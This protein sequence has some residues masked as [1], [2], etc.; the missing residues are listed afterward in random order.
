MLSWL[1]RR[2]LDAFEK[3]YAYDASYARE[4]LALS[5]KALTKFFRAASLGSYRHGLT[6]E[7]WH[8]ARLVSIVAEDCG[9]CT[10]LAVTMAERA[11]VA[12]ELIADLIAGRFEALP[13]PVRVTA[14]FT[15]ATLRRTPEADELRERVEQFFGRQGLLSI[16]FSITAS[17]MYPTLKY[18]MGYGR[19]CQ[20]VSVGGKT[21][22]P[23]SELKLHGAMLQGQARVE[24]V[25]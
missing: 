25:A 9:P 17:R 4:M 22:A 8:A 7:A 13:E 11:G 5:P 19:S 23:A 16:A 3:S 15:L 2:R 24:A 14:R 10:Q 12:P 1:I 6:R 20:H 21:L 18:A